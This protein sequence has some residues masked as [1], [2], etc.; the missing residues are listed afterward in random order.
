M[1]SIFRADTLFM[2]DNSKTK[3]TGG[4][5]SSLDG[6]IYNDWAAKSG[7][8]SWSAMFRSVWAKGA[9]SGK[10]IDHNFSTTGMMILQDGYYE[11][12]LQQRSTG[13]GDN[14]VGIGLDGRRADLEDRVDGVWTHGHSTYGNE[15]CDSYYIGKLYRGDII[16][17]GGNTSANL[18]FGTTGAYGIMRI[19]RLG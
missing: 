11:I 18:M 6:A 12:H 15:F 13:A 2:P 8:S 4:I 14:Y 10:S 16:T 7:C 1:A 19:V 3:D 9:G 17:G 5:I